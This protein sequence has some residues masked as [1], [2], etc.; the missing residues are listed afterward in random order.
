M[1]G[2][3]F[4][5]ILTMTTWGE[6]HGAGIG[7]VVD[8][9]PAGLVLAEEDIQRY[10]DRRKPGQSRYTT[11]RSE[12]DS[13]EIMSGVFEGKTTGT[14]I[15]MVIRNRD[16]HSGDYS[17]IAGFY[18]PGHADFTFD[19]KFGFRDYRGGGRSSGRETIGRVA[20]GA[21]A[22][23]ILDCLGVKVTA[24]T[25]AI[26]DIH[27]RPERFNMEECRRNSLYMPDAAAAEEAKIFLEE[28]MAQKDSAGGVVEC[29][30]EGVP[31]GIGEPVF[32]KLNANL[33]KAICSIGAVKGFE[34]GDGFEAAKTVGSVN[35]DAFCVVTDEAMGTDKAT[36]MYKAG[37]IGKRTNHSGGVLGGISD[38]SEIVFRAA[39]KPTPSI[40]SVQKTVNRDGEEIEISVKGRHDPIIVPRAVVV[41][42]MMAAFTVAD[43][44]LAGM[45]ARMDLVSEFYSDSEH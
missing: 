9:C 16:Q 7:V 27:V 35:N 36:G 28:K 23:K 39:F 45:T 40:A 31:A 26:G 41:V 30:I 14:P 8:G 12:N 22:A 34:I 3:T 6:S 5:K 19:E 42:E 25:K 44:M 21:V 2:S 13:V 29:V 20:A 43:M 18:R 10:L 1:A 15:A 24:Y 17:E 33:A 4:G 11:K 32:E 37:R 38:G